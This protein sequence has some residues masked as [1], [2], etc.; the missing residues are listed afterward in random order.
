MIKLSGINKIYRT[1][2]IETQAFEVKMGAEVME[3]L[4]KL[5]KEDGRTIVMVTH[6]ESKAQQTQ[7][8]VRFFD[9]RY[10]E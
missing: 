5:N 2:K 9:G 4:Q 7:R 6:N 3:I 1:D 8:I 10:V